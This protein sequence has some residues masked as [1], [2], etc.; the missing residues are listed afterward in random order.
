[1]PW[2]TRF[3][4]LL[5]WRWGQRYRR[6]GP[7]GCIAHWQKNKTDTDTLEKPKKNMTTASVLTTVSRYFSFCRLRCIE[8]LIHNTGFPNVVFLFCGIPTIYILNLL[9]IF[10]IDYVLYI[11]MYTTVTKY[12]YTHKSKLLTHH[13][14]ISQPSWF[15]RKNT[16]TYSP[17][18]AP[19]SPDGTQRSNLRSPR[20]SASTINWYDGWHTTI[21]CYKVGPYDRYGVKWPPPTNGR[22]KTYSW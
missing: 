18:K 16:R 10:N 6:W 14:E 3:S 9:Y 2:T 17:L 5:K 8:R 20:G 1:M 19:A 4:S 11:Y 15:L 7:S 12:V 21:I 22:T 13:L